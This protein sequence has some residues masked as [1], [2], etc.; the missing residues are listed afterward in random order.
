MDKTYKLSEEARKR[1]VMLWYA[2][3]VVTEFLRQKYGERE[4]CKKVCELKEQRDKS[5]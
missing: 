4:F 5:R 3:G 2:T 1:A